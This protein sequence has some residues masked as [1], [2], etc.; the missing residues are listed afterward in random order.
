MKN[1]KVLLTTDHHFYPSYSL[2]LLPSA[3]SQTHHLFLLIVTCVCSYVLVMYMCLGWTT[4]DW[5]TYQGTYL[6]RKLILSQQPWP[7]ALRQGWAFRISS[8]PVGMSTGMV[9]MKVMFSTMFL[10]SCECSFPIMSKDRHC[11]P[12]THILSVPASIIFPET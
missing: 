5:I 1:Y 11:G 3:S 4:W 2:Q 10:I 6:W 7:R 9:I 12:L 8:I